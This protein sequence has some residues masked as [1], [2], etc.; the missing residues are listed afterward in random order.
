MTNKEQFVKHFGNEAFE[1]ITASIKNSPNPGIDILTW[2]LEDYSEPTIKLSEEEIEHTKPAW[3]RDE[4]VKK[5][6]VE[7]KSKHSKRRSSKGRGYDL[8]WYQDAVSDFYL[9]T[10]KS[11][12]FKMSDDLSSGKKVKSLD[13]YRTRF[14]IA[15]KELGLDDEI[16]VHKYYIGTVNECVCLEKPNFKNSKA[17]GF[18]NMR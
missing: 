11:I 12:E 13:G 18:K 8:K 2:F 10:A 4:E 5:N 7:T 14:I 9:G 3:M 16:L 6:V 17:A 1:Y 15:V